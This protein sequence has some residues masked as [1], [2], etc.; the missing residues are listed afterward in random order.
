MKQIYQARARG[1]NMTTFAPPLP[2]LQGFANIRVNAGFFLC[3]PAEEG[4]LAGA[5]QVALE[6]AT[7]TS[8][9]RRRSATGPRGICDIVGGLVAAFNACACASGRDRRALVT[10]TRSCRDV[11]GHADVAGDEV[12]LRARGRRL[13]ALAAGA[14]GRPGRWAPREDRAAREALEPVARDDAFFDQQGRG[15]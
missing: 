5:F 8:A 15:R 1:A 12:S 3:R 4:R 10:T 13:E 9:D 6:H 14:L 2:G 11:G 7:C